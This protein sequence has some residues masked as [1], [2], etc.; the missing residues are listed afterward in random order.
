MSQI[1][2]GLKCL[3][4]ID[5]LIV[6]QQVELIEAFFGYEISNHY[7]IK[8]NLGKVIYEAQEGNY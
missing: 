6:H 2:Q 3:T 7:T 5:Q 8:S 1:A 4:D